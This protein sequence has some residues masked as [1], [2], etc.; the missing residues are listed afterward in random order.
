MTLLR[1][2]VAARIKGRR[3]DRR[4]PVRVRVAACAIAIGRENRRVAIVSIDRWAVSIRVAVT[5]V[6]VI[7]VS[8]IAVIGVVAIVRVLVLIL[9]AIVLILVRVLV[10]RRGL[11]LVLIFA[12]GLFFRFLLLLLRVGDAG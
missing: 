4:S 11:S 8:I 10:I 9:V 1:A 12:L 2:R 5:I 6:R 3:G 7:R